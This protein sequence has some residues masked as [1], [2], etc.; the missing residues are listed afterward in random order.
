M[1]KNAKLFIS[2]AFK[3]ILSILPLYF[4]KIP[5]MFF[6]DEHIPD[7]EK[8]DRIY[9]MLRAQRRARIFSLVIKLSI[10]ASIFYGFYYL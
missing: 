1:R 6:S 7:M 10:L 8:I 9:K 3:K 2:F 5:H 4:L